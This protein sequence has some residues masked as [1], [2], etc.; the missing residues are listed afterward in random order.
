MST[1]LTAKEI[2][3]HYNSK[4]YLD[5]LTFTLEDGDIIGLVGKNGCG[6]TSLMRI[7]AGLQDYDGGSIE[8][9]TGKRIG[10]LPQDFEFDQELTIEETLHKS[11]GWIKKLIREYDALNMKDYP[12]ASQQPLNRGNLPSDQKNEN[13]PKYSL[14]KINKRSLIANSPL[15]GG[16]KSESFDSG[17]IAV[18]NLRNNGDTVVASTVLYKNYPTPV[19]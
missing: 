14:N 6:K 8:V 7:M 17:S 15:L 9:K 10:Y 18:E 1:L 3:L 16:G 12:V 5:N 4:T 11:T 13:S 2:F 19:P